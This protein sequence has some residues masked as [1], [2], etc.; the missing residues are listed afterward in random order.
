MVPPNYKMFIFQI[1]T[2]T[3]QNAY[4]FHNL[5]VTSKSQHGIPRIR[6]TIVEGLF[7]D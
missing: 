4:N 6:V 7:H 5:Y 1:K 3:T 2:F